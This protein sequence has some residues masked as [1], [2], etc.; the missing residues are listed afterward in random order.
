MVRTTRC[1]T[2]HGRHPPVRRARDGSA[3]GWC[4]RWH[5]A[6]SRMVPPLASGTMVPPLASL[7][8]AQGGASASGAAP[9]RLVADGE[10]AHA[11]RLQLLLQHCPHGQRAVGRGGGRA[12][13]EVDGVVVVRRNELV[14]QLLRILQASLRRDQPREVDQV[15]GRHCG[16]LDVQHDRAR[17]AD[18]LLRQ[19]P[20]FLQQ[21]SLHRFAHVHVPRH[22]R[23]HVRSDHRHC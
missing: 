1:V 12:G 20:L 22:G 4:L 10:D 21:D 6:R 17:Q 3:L 13:E 11:A 15:D 18:T 9:R 2:A 8:R 7:H 19:L 23:H 16:V 5:Q 14:Y